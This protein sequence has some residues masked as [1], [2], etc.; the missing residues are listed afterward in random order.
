LGGREGGREAAEY[1]DDNLKAL[2]ALLR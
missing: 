2:P 1:K